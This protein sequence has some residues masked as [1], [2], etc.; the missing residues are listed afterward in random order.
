MTKTS[1]DEMQ[2]IDR[3]MEALARITG[4]SRK[5]LDDMMS[6]GMENARGTQRQTPQRK[7]I[8]TKSR[9]R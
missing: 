3:F 7:R 9:A 5:K 2:E 1:P 8:S 6:L 4:I